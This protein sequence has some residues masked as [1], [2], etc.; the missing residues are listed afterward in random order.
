MI[1]YILHMDKTYTDLLTKQNLVW[2]I[3][4]QGVKSFDQS[5]SSVISEKH[6]FKQVIQQ[7]QRQIN[8]STN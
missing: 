7:N 2:L 3:F 6:L 4:Y 5:Y 1:V 8:F